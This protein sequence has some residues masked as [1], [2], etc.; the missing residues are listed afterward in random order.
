MTG[1]VST[2]P[3]AEPVESETQ[4]WSFEPGIST[5]HQ[6]GLPQERRGPHSLDKKEQYALQ[7]AIQNLLDMVEN[8]GAQSAVERLRQR[9]E[10]FRSDRVTCH[11]MVRLC[12][13]CS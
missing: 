6:R 1:R 7:S 13:G 2:D 12:R 11:K 8:F 5:H 10:L 9:A 3:V 4:P